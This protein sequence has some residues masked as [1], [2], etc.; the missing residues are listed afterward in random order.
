MPQKSRS[1]PVKDFSD[2]LGSGIVIEKISLN[3]I[4]S[5]DKTT[6]NG[7]EEAGQPHRHDRRFKYSGLRFSLR[8]YPCHSLNVKERNQ[9]HYFRNSF[10]LHKIF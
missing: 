9:F 5:L 7:S 8:N 10:A 6:V 1:I 4:S 3:N 2:G